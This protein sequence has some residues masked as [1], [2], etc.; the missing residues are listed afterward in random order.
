MCVCVCGVW[1]VVYVCG[2]WC[3]VCVCGECVWCMWWCVVRACVCVVRT[4]VCVVCV[5]CV[6]EEMKLYVRRGN[7]GEFEEEDF[8]YVQ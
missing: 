3:V 6:C 2:V 1:C 4:C 5:W 7:V 8:K